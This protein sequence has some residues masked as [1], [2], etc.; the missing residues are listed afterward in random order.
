[1]NLVLH[2]SVVRAAVATVFFSY[3]AGCSREPE[4]AKESKEG[5]EKAL[6]GVEQAEE[7]FKRMR[8]R[9]ETLVQKVEEQTRKVDEQ[10]KLLDGTIAKH[11][12]ILTGRFSALEKSILVMSAERQTAFNPALADL[13]QQLSG[14]EAAFREYRDAPEGKVNESA[15]KLQQLLEKWN[16]ACAQLEAKVREPAAI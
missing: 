15:S 13:K 9:S 4:P 5:L 3:L 8:E 10:T 12:G 2:S 14:I 16:E 7:G 1:M 6:K 11:I